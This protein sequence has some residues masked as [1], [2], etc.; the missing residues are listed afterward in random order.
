MSNYKKG[1][2][3]PAEEKLSEEPQSTDTAFKGAADE[4]GYRKGFVLEDD[5]VE[6]REV[7][8]AD[9][10]T[11]DL[12]TVKEVLD[13][14]PEVEELRTRFW[15]SPF[16]LLLVLLVSVGGLQVYELISQAFLKSPLV[17]WC[18]SGGIG[19]VLV[20][21]L[22]SIY[23]EMRS[24]WQLKSNS[25]HRQKYEQIINSGSAKDAIALCRQM[26]SNSRG[27]NEQNFATFCKRVQL[28]FSPQEIFEIY[29]KT[30]LSELDK[31]AKQIVVKR[32]R[33]TGVVVALS[34]LAWIDMAFS[35][36]R[37]LRM[38]REIAHIY[39]YRCGLWGR[40]ELYRR[41]I[42]HVVYIGIADLTTD[43]L[44]DALGAETLGKLSAAAG[45]G[46]AA[47]IYSTRLGYMTIKAIRPLPFDRRV[48]TL[49]ELRREMVTGSLDV[50][51]QIRKNTKK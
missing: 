17:G 40:F 47:G 11:S 37:S 38:V 3:I 39:G 5:K 51:T 21:I 4:S 18:W 34:P 25:E 16:M 1:F 6:T 43:V 22:G 8:A 50:L 14:E 2:E 41:I 27:L 33:E 45:Q 35:L 31:K 10:D 23:S 15:T 26:F 24:V 44:T 36:A 30:V 46:I 28:N 49:G 20:L 19:A 7:A 12:S 42:R 9:V 32:S 48:L 29:E 13:E